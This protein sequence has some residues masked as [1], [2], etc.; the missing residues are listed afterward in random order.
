[1]VECQCDEAVRNRKRMHPYP[2]QCEPN[3][4]GE[5]ICSFCWEI[6][7]APYMSIDFRRRAPSPTGRVRR[8]AP[9]TTCGIH[10]IDTA[11]GRCSSCDDP[12]THHTEAKDLRPSDRIAIYGG[13]PATV[14]SVQPS[15]SHPGLLRVFLDVRGIPFIH[16]VSP[17]HSFPS[18]EF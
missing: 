7:S 18:M 13:T 17:S 4:D 11:S 15:E 14:V 2:E 3:E 9:M 10:G 6:L 16:T 8:G 5:V 12:T 1:M